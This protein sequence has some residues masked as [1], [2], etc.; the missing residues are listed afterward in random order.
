MVLVMRSLAVPFVV[1]PPGGARVRTRLRVDDQDAVV[2]VAVGEDL[3]R[4]AGRDLAARCARG[5][6]EP[7]RAV[8]KRALTAGS[9]SRWAGAIT[10]TSQDQWAQATRNLGAER[11]GL[12]RRIGVIESRLA[13]AVGARGRLAQMAANRGLWVVAVDPAYTS[14][15]VGQHWQAPLNQ[16]TPPDVTVT[17][18]QAAAVVIGRRSLGHGARRR[19]GMT[20]PHQRMGPGELPARPDT[21]PAAAREG[22]HRE[23]HRRRRGPYQTGRAQR[24]RSPDQATQDRSGPPASISP[25]DKR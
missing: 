22:E 2:L 9:S 8:R 12:R 4:L 23:A 3:G 21:K 19:P 7:G 18:H 25:A 13:V 6:G 1:A 20:D 10:R 11:V 24:A 14:K 17:R 5:R 15:W 16:Q